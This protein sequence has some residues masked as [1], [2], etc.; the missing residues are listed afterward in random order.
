MDN[1]SKINGL[2]STTLEKIKELI[3]TN[4]VM[5]KPVKVGD[6]V[7]VIPVIKVSWGFASGGSDFGEK[8]SKDLFGGG[9][10][11]GV[12][13]TP[14]A[15]MVVSPTGVKMLQ[16]NTASATVDNIVQQ[17]PEMVDKISGI[18]KK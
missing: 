16:I 8:A 1:N 13:L 15:F 10:G 18:I 3:D 9:S 2:A 17:M 5:G 4:A 7:T 11:A 6:D 12:T 14:T